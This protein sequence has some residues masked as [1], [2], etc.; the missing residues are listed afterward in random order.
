VNAI[1]L[2]GI[3]LVYITGITVG[4]LTVGLMYVCRWR[5]QCCN[6]STINKMKNETGDDSPDCLKQDNPK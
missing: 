4:A 1:E 6:A 5:K 2:F 3:M